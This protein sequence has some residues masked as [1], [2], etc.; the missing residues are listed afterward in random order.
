MFNDYLTIIE[1]SELYSLSEVYLR[2]LCQFRFEYLG[3]A[4]LY[5][6][7]FRTIWIIHRPSFDAWY[8]QKYGQKIGEHAR[9][10]ER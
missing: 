7:G 1:I 4:K 10:L 5:G 6:S 2:K 9:V 8:T 3:I